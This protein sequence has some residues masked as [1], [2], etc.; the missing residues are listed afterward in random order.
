LGFAAVGCAVGKMKCHEGKQP[1][2]QL[3]DYPDV[4]CTVTESGM[5]VLAAAVTVVSA[6]PT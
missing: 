4:S 1:G 2:F 5:Q 6:V 3:L